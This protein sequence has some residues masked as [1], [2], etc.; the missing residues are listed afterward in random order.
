MEE[1]EQLVGEGRAGKTES[2]DAR[3]VQRDLHAALLR[4]ALAVSPNAPK[5]QLG[6]RRM[7]RATDFRLQCKLWALKSEASAAMTLRACG[8]DGRRDAMLM[9]DSNHR[10]LRRSARRTRRGS[11]GLKKLAAS[12]I[13][14][15]KVS[16]V[17]TGGA[18]GCAP[19]F[20]ASPLAVFCF[21]RLSLCAE[22]HWPSLLGSPSEC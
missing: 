1:G 2:E 9:R 20:S 21:A 3:P 5:T 13:S 8:L 11:R 22:T 19:S 17:G 4:C 15:R 7:P 10:R 18:G 6:A 16:S 12:A 14:R